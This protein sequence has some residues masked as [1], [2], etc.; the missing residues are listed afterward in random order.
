MDKGQI[1]S[2]DFL[3]SLV[4]ITAAVG[5]MVQAI[6]VNTYY[7][8]ESRDFI[9]MKAVAETAADLLIASQATTCYDSDTD[10]YMI[11]CVRNDLNPGD[12]DPLVPNKFNY[13]VRSAS[14]GVNLERFV[15]PWGEEDYY[16]AK[17][18][19]YINNVGGATEELTVRV[20]RL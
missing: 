1:F 6:E 12:T 18:T 11:Q 4:A 14:L 8:K 16:M 17:R 15:N 10:Q 3:I 19:I 13:K 9:E 7:Q 5:L 2:L 20:W